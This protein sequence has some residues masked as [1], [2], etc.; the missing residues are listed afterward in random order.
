MTAV[1]DHCL[2]KQQ[3]LQILTAACCR[4]PSTR[5]CGCGHMMAA[6][7]FLKVAE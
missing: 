3:T 2:M 1:S 6:N 5:F 4:W 7:V